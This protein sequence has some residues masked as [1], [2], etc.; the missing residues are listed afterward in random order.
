[1]CRCWLSL[2]CDVFKVLL[3][4][5]NTKFVDN[6]AKKCLFLAM[7]KQRCFSLI[8]IKR[9]FVSCW[10]IN[11]ICLLNVSSFSSSKCCKISP[12]REKCSSSQKSVIKSWSHKS[13]RFVVSF[14]IAIAIMSPLQPKSYTHR[15]TISAATAVADMGKRI[16]LNFS[17]FRFFC[18]V[19]RATKLLHL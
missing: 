2:K 11:W 7:F 12:S 19:K 18:S 13:Y 3:H 10:Q 1:M 14:F 8:M 17:S 16:L 4:K 5:K 6:A 9:S 15:V